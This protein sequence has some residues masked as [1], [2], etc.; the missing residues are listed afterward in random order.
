MLKFFLEKSAFSP[1]LSWVRSS[2][3]PVFGWVCRSSGIY[4]VIDIIVLLTTEKSSALWIT[5]L[6]P[7]GKTGWPASGSACGSKE[8]PPENRGASLFAISTGGRQ[9]FMS[10]SLIRSP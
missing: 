9:I 3:S 4:K 2:E 6:G 8:A 1:H 7:V 10:S 5:G